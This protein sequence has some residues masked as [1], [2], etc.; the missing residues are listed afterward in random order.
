M[1]EN[2]T[3]QSFL[4]Y[5]RT[6]GPIEFGGKL[7]LRE[8]GPYKVPVN[9]LGAAC[10]RIFNFPSSEFLHADWENFTRTCQKLKIIVSSHVCLLCLLLCC[11]AVAVAQRSFYATLLVRYTVCLHSKQ[12]LTYTHLKQVA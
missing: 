12:L 10:P 6:E 4:D 7:L 11:A 3:D 2:A 9:F 1:G 5:D 8:S